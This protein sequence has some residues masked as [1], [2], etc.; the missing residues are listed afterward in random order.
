VRE[1]T[2]RWLSVAGWEKEWAAWLCVQSKE[3]SSRLARRREKSD[4][5]GGVAAPVEVR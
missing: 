2:G 4:Q 5:E 3:P 1:A